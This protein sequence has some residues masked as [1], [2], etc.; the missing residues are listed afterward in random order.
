MLAEAEGSWEIKFVGRSAVA[1]AEE[2]A[3]CLT[4]TCHEK[5]FY[6]VVFKNTICQWDF[7]SGILSS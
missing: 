7:Q 3:A 4:E 6:H 1:R 5:E 2:P